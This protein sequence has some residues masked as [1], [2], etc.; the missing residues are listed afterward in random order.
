MLLGNRS[1]FTRPDGLAAT[2]K[3]IEPL[4]A[5]RPEPA[6]YQ[7]GSWGPATARELA[8]PGRWLLGQ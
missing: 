2:W 7:P 4:L 1:L 8:K 5:D 3:T 6:S